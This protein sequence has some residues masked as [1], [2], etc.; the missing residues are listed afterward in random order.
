MLG[1][2]TPTPGQTLLIPSGPGHHL[3]FLVLGPVIVPGHGPAP[4]MALVNATSIKLGL[5]HDTACELGVADHPF[6]K[7]PSF[8][9][10]RY[11][12]VEDSAHI[13]SMVVQSVWKLG[14]PCTAELLK[15]I[16]TGALQS[17]LI[18]REYKALF[19]P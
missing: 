12:R 8:I 6:I 5:S 13:Q 11:L 14:Q 10:Y 15:K 18:S 3:F 1:N 2:W 16:M 7:H 4:K 17:R 19:L 9:A